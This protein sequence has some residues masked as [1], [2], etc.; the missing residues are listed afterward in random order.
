MEAKVL[1]FRRP[2]V[3]VFE[4]FDAD[5][6]SAL[7]RAKRGTDTYHFTLTLEGEVEEACIRRGEYLIPDD[8]FTKVEDKYVEGLVEEALAIHKEQLSTWGR[9]STGERI[10]LLLHWGSETL[11][12]LRSAVQAAAQEDPVEYSEEILLMCKDIENHES[13]LA[14]LDTALALL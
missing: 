6:M 1:P 4:R 12:H 10:A 5:D 3:V 9:L 14:G 13:Y 8:E 2:H 7:F 11:E